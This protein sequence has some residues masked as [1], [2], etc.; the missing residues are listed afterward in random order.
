M[1]QKKLNAFLIIACVVFVVL[2]T[3]ASGAQFLALFSMESYYRSITISGIPSQVFFSL[4][5]GLINVILYTKIFGMFFIDLSEKLE[6]IAK[7]ME[8]RSSGS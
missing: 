1:L 2:L 3:I 6:R 8:Q 4:L 7:A 5:G